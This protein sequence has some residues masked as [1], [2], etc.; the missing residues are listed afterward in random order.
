MA[1]ISQAARERHKHSGF[2]WGPEVSFTAATPSG[3]T[4]QISLAAGDRIRFLGRDDE[5]GVVNGSA[6]TIVNVSETAQSSSDASRILIEADINGRQTTFD[7]MRLADA[8][9]RPRLGWAYAS[10]DYGSQG[11]TVD[12]AIAYLDHSY[13]RHDIYVAASRARERTTLVLDAKSIDRRLASELP[14]DQ[15]RDGL[16]F[17]EA[18]R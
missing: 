6:A 17:A 13:N 4:A 3:H 11:L 5:L 18:Q 9:G 7:P 15:Q 16:V 1:A 14:F 10:T 2:I 8:Q 12:H